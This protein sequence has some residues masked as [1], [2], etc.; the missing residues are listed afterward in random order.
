S[1]KSYSVHVVGEQERVEPV[2]NVSAVNCG[3]EAAV[4]L[5]ADADL[6]TTAVGPQIRAKIAGTIAK[7]LVLR[8][9]QGNVQPLNII[10]C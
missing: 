5:I 10:A 8:Q 3:G 1:R 6:V 4:A 2:T 7:G 9:Q